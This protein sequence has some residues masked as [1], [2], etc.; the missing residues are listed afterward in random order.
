MLAALE[1]ARKQDE[2]TRMIY[3]LRE[4]AE[5]SQKQLARRM[6]LTLTTIRR[7]EDADYEGNSLAMLRKI[8]AALGKRIELRIADAPT[9][10]SA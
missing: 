8:A 9:A 6:G 1:R 7:L 4:Q 3:C 10:R 2:I 5:L